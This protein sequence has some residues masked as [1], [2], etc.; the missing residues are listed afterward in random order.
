MPVTEPIQLNNQ[1]CGSDTGGTQIGTVT[2]SR[3]KG[4]LQVEVTFTGAAANTTYGIDVW[5][6]S[7]CTFTGVE[8]GGVTTDGSGDGSGTFQ[9]KVKGSVFFINA[10]NTSDFSGNDS[11]IAT[12]G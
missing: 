6:G 5:N 11:L 12:L 9:A 10:V 3:A 8:V 2:F 4:K 1:S 7:N